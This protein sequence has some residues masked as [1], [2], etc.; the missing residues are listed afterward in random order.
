MKK[1]V[2]QKAWELA[3]QGAVQFGGNAREYFSESLRMAW[4]KIKEES[5]MERK[6]DE[7]IKK[8]NIRIVGENLGADKAIAKHPEDVKMIKDNKQAIIKHIKGKEEAKKQ[9]YLAYKASVEAIEGLKEIETAMYSW[10][11]WNK[12]FRKSFD[13]EYAVG[14]MGIE[15]PVYTEDVINSLK[16]KY[17]RATAFLKAESWSNASHYYKSRLG[18]DA[19]HRIAAGEDYKKVISEIETKWEEYRAENI[20]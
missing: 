9:E 8:Y 5:S 1:K 17:P 16:A 6:F 2:M 3:K 10:A 18:E 7:L 15:S 19:K 12:K 4:K 13:G 14:G 11:E 20:D